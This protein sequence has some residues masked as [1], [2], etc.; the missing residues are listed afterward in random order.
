[1]LPFVFSKDL[2]KQNYWMEENAQM[3]TFGEKIKDK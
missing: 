2:R 1:M 3:Q